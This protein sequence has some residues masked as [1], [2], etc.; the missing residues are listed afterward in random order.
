MYPGEKKKLATILLIV[1]ELYYSDFFLFRLK[2]KR[3]QRMEGQAA[4]STSHCFHVLAI[5]NS[6]A[7]NTGV[8]VSFLIIFFLQRQDCRSGIA[9][10]MS[11]AATWM[12]LE[13]V[14]LNEANQIEKYR[15]TSLIC[16]I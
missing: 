5:A 15:M 3:S 9:G 11:F 2:G 7:T 12:G 4:E 13:G 16:G 1:F 6:A 8:H 10:I 14:I